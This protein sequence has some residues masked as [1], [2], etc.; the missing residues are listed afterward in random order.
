MVAKRVARALRDE[1]ILVSIG[2]AVMPGFESEGVGIVE[3]ADLAL[4]R[5]KRDGKGRIARAA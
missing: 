5:A 3:A 4:L 2:L 1:G